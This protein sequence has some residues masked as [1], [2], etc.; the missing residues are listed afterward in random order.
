MF[1]AFIIYLHPGKQTAE[2]NTLS[3]QGCCIAGSQTTNTLILKGYDL[4]FLN[5]LLIRQDV[6]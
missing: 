5:D 1:P 6:T 4:D 2:L 3:K